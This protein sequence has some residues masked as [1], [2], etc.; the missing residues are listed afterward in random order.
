M[1]RFKLLRITTVDLSL[2]TLLKGQMRYMINH[3]FEVVMISADTGMQEKVILSEGCRHIAVQM[4]RQISVFRDILC[5]IQ[6]T[7]L[8]ARL[9][10]DIVHTHTSK[11]GLLGMLASFLCR[12]PFRIHTVAG[13][14]PDFHKS[15]LKSIVM[16]MT[17]RLTFKVATNVWPNSKSLY[18]FIVSNKF[19]DNKKLEIIGSGSS[20]GVNLEFYSAERLNVE[21]LNKY[22]DKYFS[23]QG[24]YF[25][26]VGRI[27]ADKGIIELIDA[28]SELSKNITNI[29]LMLVGPYEVHRGNLPAPTIQMIKNN[30]NI[31]HLIWTDDVA[32]FLSLSNYVIHPSHREGFPNILLQA[33]ALG[34]PILASNAVGNRDCVRHLFTGFLF[35]T[36]N[37]E[38][39]KGA[40]KYALAEPERMKVYSQEW[41]S[42][43]VNNY[44]QSRIHHLLHQKYM[45]LL[46]NE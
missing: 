30:Q 7:Y 44:S 26:Y 13:T 35:E 46:K 33:G 20:N 24:I 27:I 6:L 42:E 21:L 34:V 19:T 22:K 17:E 28:F 43:V 14:P 10:P 16:S 4:A 31:K 32:Y 11:A 37:K 45:K 2:A 39:I 3:G 23:S 15:Q 12:I 38:A 8:I 18:E 5:L 1:K 40:I 41:H 36:K 29:F 25:I 9:R